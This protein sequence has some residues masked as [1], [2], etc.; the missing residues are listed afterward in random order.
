MLNLSNFI[1]R[2][3]GT[4]EGSFY[5][6]YQGTFKLNE[7]GKLTGLSESILKDIYTINGG[8]YDKSKDVYYFSS[9]ESAKEA[10]LSIFNKLD[11]KHKGRVVTFTENEI[12]FLRR[13]LINE[14]SNT[15]NMNTKIKDEIFKKLNG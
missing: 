8:M 1:V 13:A 7:L 9:N 10:V 6:D 15:I 2:T 14:G 11:S 4:R 12:E 5:I 3:S